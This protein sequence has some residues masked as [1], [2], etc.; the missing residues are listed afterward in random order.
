M[1]FD[2][3]IFDLDGTLADT[4]PAHYV[5]WRA[6]MEKYGISFDED[7]FYALGGRPSDKIVEL[8]SEEQGIALDPHTVA[9]EKEEAFLLEIG[10]VA[11]I[12]ATVELVYEYRG[13]IPMAVATGAMRYVADLILG[14]IGLSNHFDVCVTSEDTTRHKPHPD[15][16]LEAAKRLGVEPEHC[17]V[18]EDADLGVE[19][20]RRA[21]MEV[22]DVRNFFTPRRITV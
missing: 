17:R 4:M 20:A 16:F 2:A 5:A 18:Y 14:H 15:V 9:I 1:V 11:P 21:G 12:E 22:V 3:L 6:T 7:R 8:L 13:R 10:N 19:A